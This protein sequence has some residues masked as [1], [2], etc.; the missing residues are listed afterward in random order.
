[1]KRLLFTVLLTAFLGLQSAHAQ[2]DYNDTI[3]PIFDTYCTVCHGGLGGVTL[4]SYE[5]VMA[6]FSANYDTLIVIPE[7][8]FESPL[9]DLISS[10]D[11]QFGGRMPPGDSLSVQQ[12]E[13][14]IQWIEEGAHQSVQTSGE[15]L[16]D[17]PDAYRLNGN[18]PNPF[19][20]T[21]V[22]Q[23]VVPK[24]TDYLLSVH[25]V[26]G[27]LIREHQGTARAGVAQVALDMSRQSSGVYI[28]RIRFS[29]NRNDT[30]FLTGQ[31]TLIK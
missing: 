26:T 8:P 3:Q 10:D 11:P 9:V 12:I 7:K 23:F 14:I 1:M 5:D 18:Y 21:T 16:A 30:R 25:S 15:P 29:A 17:L 22:I 20:P 2:I 24:T 28:Y 31:M 13:D 6:S 27:K 19:N 4:E